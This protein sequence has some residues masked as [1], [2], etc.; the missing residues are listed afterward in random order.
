MS[1]YCSEFLVHG[2]DVEGKRMG[3]DAE[4]LKLLGEFAERNR[5]CV[6]TYAGGVRDLSDLEIVNEYGKGRVDVTIGSAL[7]MFGGSLS[8]AE[9]L[10][11]HREHVSH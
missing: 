8:Y 11:W 5:E 4:L 1:E 10:R 3:V 2:V 7:D 6:V 9:V